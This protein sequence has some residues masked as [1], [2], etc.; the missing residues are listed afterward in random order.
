MSDRADRREKLRQRM[1]NEAA[2]REQG[3]G[4]VP[5]L[6]LS[7]YEDVNWFKAKKGK[8]EIDILPFEITT[9]NDPGGAVIGEDNYKLEIWKHNNVGPKE[10]QVLCLQETYNKACPICEAKKEM[11]DAGADWK[12]DEV[13]ALSPKRRC[14]YNVIDLNDT[15]KHVQLFEQ[16]HFKFEKELFG[17]AEY[18]DP[19]FICFADIEE[20]YTV[21]F[22]GSEETF[23]KNKFIEPKD[24][25][26]EE[27]EAYKEDIYN[28]VYPLDAMLIIPTYEQVQALFMGVDTEEEKQPKK[29]TSSKRKSKSTRT[30]AKEGRESSKKEEKTENPARGGR[31]GRNSEPEEKEEETSSCP[32]DHIIGVDWDN[33]ESCSNCNDVDFD[34]CSKIYDDLEELKKKQ[35]KKTE[36]KP[37]R[38]GRRR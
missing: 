1:Q 33:K 35:E 23:N 34:K 27:R 3:S 2:T 11:L 22:R 21:T 13:K 6:N 18:K 28:D 32:S 26:F 12:D 31:R 30:E 20:G 36:N 29:E 19:A 14:I 7:D 24:F 9:E 25:D 8:N 15:E 5:L 17:A 38:G 10:A 4:R 16:S 37:A